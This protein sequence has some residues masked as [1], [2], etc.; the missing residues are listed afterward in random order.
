MPNIL[1]KNKKN[2]TEKEID[3]I[4]FV[5]HKFSQK[6]K[7]IDKNQIAIICSFSEFGCETLTSIYCIPQ[8]KKDNPNL[9]YIVVGWYGRDYLYKHLVDEFWELKEEYQ[10]LR[11]HCNA[12]HHQSKNLDKLE[13]GFKNL[14]TVFPSNHMSNIALGNKC[15]SCQHFWASD[16]PC[17]CCPNCQSKEF[18]PSLLGGIK[19]W[20]PKATLI[21]K[22]CEEKLKLADKYLRPNSVALTAR[23]RKTYGRNLQPEFYEKLIYLLE[24]FGYNPIWVGEKQSTLPCPV[25]R[26]CDFSRREES[27]DLELTLAIISKCIFSIQAFTA[28]TR[29]SAIMNIPYLIFESL[30]QTYMNGQENQRQALTTFTPRKLCISHYKNMFNNNDK[31]LKLV[32]RCVGEMQ[33]GDWSDVIGLVEDEG[34]T[35]AIMQQNAWKNGM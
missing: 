26:I 27:K 18:I 9:Y 7:P 12:F 30:D 1:K 24:S 6:P 29:L 13:K 28:S 34:L 3:N 25:P 2:D 8:I 35:R 15:N 19:Y 20:K 17:E 5:V 11:D 16:K 4:N 14:G 21:P 22:P 10:W 33:R 31:S 32:Q 23:G